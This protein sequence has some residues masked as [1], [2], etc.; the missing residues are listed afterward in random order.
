MRKFF[1]KYCGLLASLALAFTIGTANSTYVISIDFRRPILLY[2]GK[3]KMEQFTLTPAIQN[4][5]RI[6]L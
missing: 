5:R 6:F 3:T 4:N 1:S 2:E